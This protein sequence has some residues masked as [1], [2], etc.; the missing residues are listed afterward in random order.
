MPL[1]SLG[2]YY[3]FDMSSLTPVHNRYEEEL[4]CCE[5]DVLTSTWVSCHFSCFRA[6][7]FFEFTVSFCRRR[8]SAHTVRRQTP[9]AI[10]RIANLF[11]TDCKV[12][13]STCLNTVACFWGPIEF[14]GSQCLIPNMASRI[15]VSVQ[16]RPTTVLAIYMVAVRPWSVTLAH[17]TAQRA[18]H[19]KSHRSRYTGF[20]IAAVLFLLLQDFL[21]RPVLNFSPRGTRAFTVFSLFCNEK[22]SAPRR[23]RVT[24]AT[25]ICRTS[26]VARYVAHPA[27]RVTRQHILPVR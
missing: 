13:I 25:K 24:N 5:P 26:L 22:I 23:T 27:L 3:T 15:P 21:L 8:S 4:V 12:P 17:V 9:R 1:V 2:I 20:Y 18:L 7:Y 14:S 11:E 6:E 16:D 19:A 10:T